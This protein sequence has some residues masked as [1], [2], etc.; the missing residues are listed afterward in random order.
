VI[1][2]GLCLDLA[3]DAGIA[4][5]KAAHAALKSTLDEAAVELPQNQGGNDL[6]L[7]KL[8]CAVI[9]M[10]HDIRK[11]GGLEPIDT[12]AGVFIEGD[13]IYE[14]AGFFEKTHIQVCVR[15]PRLIRGVFRVSAD[16][17]N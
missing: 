14:N 17:L 11:S 1:E 9:T 16:E 13:R 6:W 8:D 7:R 15:D 5:L 10:L 3:T 12:V 4:Q 2:P